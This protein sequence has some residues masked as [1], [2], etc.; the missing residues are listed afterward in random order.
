MQRTTLTISTE[1]RSYTVQGMCDNI[2][3]LFDHLVAC[4][5]NPTKFSAETQKEEHHE[6]SENSKE[7]VHEDNTPQEEP[8][9]ENE[10]VPSVLNE[11]EEVREESISPKEESAPTTKK[12]HTERKTVEEDTSEPK[13]YKGFLIIKCEHCGKVKA[14]NSRNELSSYKCSC[15][16]ETP[17]SNMVP[18]TALCECGERWRYFTNITDDSFEISCL[19]CGSPIPVFFND[20]KGKYETLMEVLPPQKSK[21]G[22]KKGGKK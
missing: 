22:K 4:T 14:F 20:K 1:S 16:G 7:V 9:V 12:A 19:H 5:L 13:K 15:G 11:P 17:L 3:S 10:D 2:E 8:V 21:K 6:S 18:V